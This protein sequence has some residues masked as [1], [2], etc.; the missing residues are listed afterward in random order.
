MEELQKAQQLIKTFHQLIWGQLALT[1]TLSLAP[2]V[3]SS[4]VQTFS[5]GTLLSSERQKEKHSP[6]R[7]A[8]A[9]SCP[10]HSGLR[11]A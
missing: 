7:A 4:F 3:V 6:I 8:G 1:M 9:F 5:F 10:I 2:V 11:S